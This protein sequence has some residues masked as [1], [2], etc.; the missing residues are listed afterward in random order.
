VIDIMD[1][2]KRGPALKQG[3]EE[4]QRGKTD[5]LIIYQIYK[6]EADVWRWSNYGVE[7]DV[8]KIPKD[9]LD[10][11]VEIGGT[12][13]YLWPLV[14]ASQEWC[15]AWDFRHSFEM[16]L[17]DHLDHAMMNRTMELV[18]HRTGMKAAA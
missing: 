11:T 16:V 18:R 14:V 9:L 13:F 8:W 15:S 4:T 3:Q 2:Q 5:M 12:R 10:A 6:G 7:S 1:K 17:G